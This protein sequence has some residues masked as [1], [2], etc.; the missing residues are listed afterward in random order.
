MSSEAELAQG[1]KRIRIIAVLTALL[2][3]VGTL[4]FFGR[5]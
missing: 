1:L 3:A 2:T 4:L 5:Q